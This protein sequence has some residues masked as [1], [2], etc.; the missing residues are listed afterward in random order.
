MKKLKVGVIG[1]GSIA[2]KRHLIEYAANPNVEIVA[3]CDVIP[4]RVEETAMEYRAKSFINYKEVLA[5]PEID[6]ISICLPN[7]LHAPVSIDALNA[8]KHVLC[9]KPMA[10]SKQEAE[11]MIDAARKNNKTLMIGHNQRFVASHQKAKQLIESGVI[12]KIYSFRTT[13]GHPGPEAWSID[14][15]SSWFFNKEKA[16][17]G[18]LGD[19]GVHKADLVR[20]LL[21]EVTE[22]GAFVETS[23]KEN[24]DVD[25]NAVC[26]VKTENGVIGTLVASWSYVSGGDNSTVIY[27]ENAV[28][29]LEDDP[30]YSLIVQYKNGE[31]VKYELDKIQTNKAGGQTNSHVIDH[32][33]DA[34]LNNKSPLITGEEGKK[35]LEVI[36]AA[37]ESNKTSKF[38]EINTLFVKSR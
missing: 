19:L 36:L 14:G 1:C 18:A 24:T 23:A 38:I 26:V 28:L 17:I 9:E 13:F 3:V 30:E 33:V 27:G 34:I 4:E 32:F 7:S 2:K 21:G 8:G 25:D 20:Y 5:I 31:T 10:T 6:V 11:D 37:L 12:G 29:R 16:Y 35:S 15:A 22:I